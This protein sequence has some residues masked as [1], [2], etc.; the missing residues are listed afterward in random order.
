MKA[1][2]AAK[3][4]TEREEVMSTPLTTPEAM[5]AAVE[6]EIELASAAVEAEEPLTEE[7]LEEII[8]AIV[9]TREDDGVS[10]DEEDIAWNRRYTDEELADFERILLEESTESE[11]AAHFASKLE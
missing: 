3:L 8:N 4:A 9:D 6:A 11:R 2:Y 10:V 5:D 7:R 1:V